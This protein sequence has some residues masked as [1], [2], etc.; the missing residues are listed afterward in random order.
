[1]QQEEKVESQVSET[2][3]DEIESADV[4]TQEVIESAIETIESSIKLPF[5]FA[6]RQG[7]VIR[8]PE[9][10]SPVALQKETLKA[11]VKH[12]TPLQAIAETRRFAGRKVEFSE[13]GEDE[14]EAILSEVYQ[15][16]SGE[17]MAAMEDIGDDMDLFR[18]AEE[19]PETEDL[20]EADDDAPIIKLINA[21]LTEAIKVN[22][23][24]IHIETFEND[25]KVRF[26]VDGVLR[27][28]L[29]PSKKLAPLLV[30]RIKVMAKLDIAEKRIP[31]DGRI[32]LK[33]AN[34]GVDVRVSTIPSSHGE[35]VVLRLLDKQAGR[36]DFS[37]L[38]MPSAL[39]EKMSDILH[40]PHGIILVTGP[41]GSGKTTTLYAG[42]T[43]LNSTSRNILTVED[44]I[45]YLLDGIGQTQVNSKVDMTFARGLR[46][47]LRQ[48]PDVVMVGEI[49]DLETAQIA[50]QASLTG[51]LVL[52][53]LHTNTASGAVTRL[54]DMGIEPF[55][56]SSSLLGVLAQRLVRTLCPSCKKPAKANPKECELMGFDGNNPP[57]IY[58]AEGC[59]EC[60][61]LGYRGRQGIFELLLIDEEMRDKIHNGAS[62]LDIE[63][64]ARAQNF[65]IREDG[66][67][68]V[69]EGITTIE[70]VLRVTRED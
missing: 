2:E 63:R 26:R 24:D 30:S 40:K 32:A 11:V 34:R 37:H 15:D 28:M 27:E 41:T 55:L 36:L 54:Q 45:E 38:G 33:I 66:K 19:I 16:N 35:R 67:S 47:I 68:R 31:Q 13:V 48:D 8:L 44:P 50:V 57:T 49:R 18:L 70:E 25:L 61:N 29:S 14:F 60:N 53:T 62:E 9:D 69:L 42:L 21:L 1:M 10:D 56:L 17:A 64:H 58:H 3:G 46:A 43:L 4:A 59:V 7:V 23:S 39:M 22:A 12:D 6:K 65:S 52:S 51:H 5:T 20:L